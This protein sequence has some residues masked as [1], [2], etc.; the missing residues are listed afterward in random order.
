MTCRLACLR[1][2]GAH[3]TN[4]ADAESHAT[5]G[6][7]LA[8][9]DADRGLDE[10]VGERRGDGEGE[11][12]VRFSQVGADEDFEGA[13]GAGGAVPA[14]PGGLGALSGRGE[15]NGDAQPIGEG[16]AKLRKG[17]PQTAGN[18]VEP[19]FAVGVLRGGVTWT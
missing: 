9:L 10:L 19:A 17:W 16:R 8:G 3:R 4:Q 5:E 7:S 12:A 13:V 6:G 11:H 15:A 1:G 18:I 14:F 2:R